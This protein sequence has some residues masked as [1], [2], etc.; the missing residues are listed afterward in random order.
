M[1]PSATLET[2]ESDQKFRFLKQFNSPPF[3]KKT[4]CK[5][6]LRESDIRWFPGDYLSSVFAR[7]LCKNRAVP[8]KEVLESFEFYECV[9]KH[10]R[11]RAV[12]D[13][14]CG[15]GLVGILFAM[16]ERETDHVVLLDKIQPP[17]FRVVLD[18]AIEIAPWVGDKIEYIISPLEEAQNHLAMQTAIV[19]VHACGERTDAC[20]DHA[21]ELSG[22]VAVLP[23]CRHHRS[24]DSPPCLK[25]MLGGDV[26]IDVDR[27]YRL[28]RAGYHVRWDRIPSAITEMNRVLVGVQRESEGSD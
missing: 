10:L 1:P 7:A 26:A 11:S 3:S 15:H 18:T 8:F 6:K 16:F 27:T 21:I 13:L 20:I 2:A 12:A 5:D 19:G 17:S 14:C 22:P 9:R 28:H 4:S 23:C 24:Y 25:A